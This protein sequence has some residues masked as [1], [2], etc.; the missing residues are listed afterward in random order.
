M[1][2]S[3]SFLSNAAEHQPLFSWLKD[4][5]VGVLLHP[6][7]LPSEFGVGTFDSSAHDFLQFLAHAGVKY[8]QLCPLG[9]TG[10]GDSPYQCFS[11]FAG[12][13]YLIDPAPLVAAGLL[14]DDSLVPL[15]A[16]AANRVEYGSLYRLKWPLL[17]AAHAAWRKNPKRALPYGDFAV[18][19]EQNASWLAS[20]ALFSALKDN[21]AGQPWWEWPAAVRSGA[22]AE[23]APRRR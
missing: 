16:L 10:F 15:R 8:W 20:Y 4:R 6:T 9:P 18:F 12:N 13:A 17:F 14:A 3:T 11:S 7:A 21:F 19:R 2:H 5:A 1:D 22:G 23:K